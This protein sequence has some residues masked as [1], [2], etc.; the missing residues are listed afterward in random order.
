MDIPLVSEVIPSNHS[1]PWINQTE[2]NDEKSF[3]IQICQ[4]SVKRHLLFPAKKKKT[5]FVAEME[6]VS[7]IHPPMELRNV[8]LFRLSSCRETTLTTGKYYSWRLHTL[9]EA[10]YV[11]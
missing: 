6:N 4:N 3:P 2:P 1:L 7:T 9:N 8:S 10:W 11:Q 5:P